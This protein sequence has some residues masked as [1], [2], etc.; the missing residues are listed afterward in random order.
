MIAAAVHPLLQQTGVSRRPPRLTSERQ[1]RWVRRLNKSCREYWPDLGPG[2]TAALARRAWARSGGHVVR[3]TIGDQPISRSFCLKWCPAADP[4]AMEQT[5]RRVTWW[6]QHHPKLRKQIA[7]VLA[8]WPDEMVLVME[9][10]SGRSLGRYLRNGLAHSTKHISG[11][12]RY[13]SEL[14]EWFREFAEVGEV[15]G[16]E[17]QPMLG[18]LVRSNADGRLVVDARRLLGQRIERGERAVSVLQR[19]GLLAKRSWA[20]RFDLDD[21]VSSFGDEEP[22]GFIHGDLKP[23]NVLVDENGLTIIDWWTTPRVSW[24]LSDVA[25]F[26]GNLRLCGDNKEAERLWR[27]FAQA[28]YPGGLDERTKQAIEFVGTVMCLTVLAEQSQRA[29]LRRPPISELRKRCARQLA[30]TAGAITSL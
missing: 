1:A 26:A 8:F 29:L 16:V 2:A 6:R 19:K 21:I 18:L 23:D 9:W 7:P 14:G 27:S 11:L 20:N 5:L 28:R 30:D 12:E 10:R 22:A 25:T 13:G 4:V 24:P 15:F 17:I 3:G